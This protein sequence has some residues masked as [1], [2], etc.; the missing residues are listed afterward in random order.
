M[1]ASGVRP[2]NPDKLDSELGFSSLISRHFDSPEYQHKGKMWFSGGV[3]SNSSLERQILSNVSRA[4]MEAK[5]I[6]R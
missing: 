6:L 5:L 3:D 2:G 1:D 4:D